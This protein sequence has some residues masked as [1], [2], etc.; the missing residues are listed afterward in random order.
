MKFH[1]IHPLCFY[2][3][4]KAIDAFHADMF[5]GKASRGGRQPHSKNDRGT[6][7]LDRPMRLHK[8][9]FEIADFFMPEFE[10]VVSASTKDALSEMSTLRFE[11]VVFEAMYSYPY[12][13]NDFSFWNELKDYYSQ[14]DFIDDQTDD[15]LLHGEVGAYY[16]MIA[17]TFRENRTRFRDWRDVS[18]EADP[19]ESGQIEVAFSRNLL[20]DAGMYCTGT[21]VVAN[22]DVYARLAPFIDA[23]YFTH[24][25]ADA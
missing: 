9:V 1:V 25:V 11:R 22:D 21:K 5:H 13:A 3:N 14:Q 17:P 8:N 6:Y 24:V 7:E 10:C 20:T 16:H 4:T 23:N 2:G 18:L 19:R 12:R 15:P